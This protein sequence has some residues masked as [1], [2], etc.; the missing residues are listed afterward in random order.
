MASVARA[1]YTPFP[2]SAIVG[3]DEP[4]LAL[5][6]AAINPRVGG[7]LL[8]GPKGTGKTTLVRAAGELLPALE[9]AT[10]PYGCDPNGSNLCAACAATLESG[11]PLATKKTRGEIVELPVNAQLDD[12][13]GAIDLKAA[14]ER[15]T[16]DFRPGLLARANRN[17]L[18]VDEVNLLSDLVVDALLDAAAQGVVHVKRGQHA[19]DYPSR[20]TLIGTMN[21][22]EGELRPQITDRIGLRVFVRS[23]PSFE[24]RLEIY[25]RNASFARDAR[26][27]TATFEGAT[28]KLRTKLAQA[29]KRIESVRV[30]AAAE[31]AAI[32]ATAR[33]G[34]DSHRT[35]FVAL[36]AATALAAWEGRDVATPADV[37]RVFPL[38]ARLR[39]SRL[40]VEAQSEHLAEDAAIEAA[41]EATL[42][43]GANDMPEEQVEPAP[44]IV[45]APELT[46]KT[47]LPERPQREREGQPIGSQ[48][49]GPN[50]RL[51]IGA[52][53]L[54][55]AASSRAGISPEPK[56]PVEAAT[57]PRLSIL[58]VDASLSTQK[59]SELVRA[60]TRELL[61]PVYTDRERAALISCWGPHATIAVD[62]NTGRNID[63]VAARLDELEPGAVRALT[64]LP[65]ALELA[66]TIAERFRRAHA[67]AEVDIAVFSDGR[68]NV[69]LGGE[70]MLAAALDG[71]G[72][73]ELGELAAE[74]C[75]HIAS[76]LAGRAKLTCVNL[77]E[78]E[79][80]PLMREIATLARGT[81]FPLSSVV[82]KIL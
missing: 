5:I 45:V 2:F 59:S 62:E 66:R 34:I 69:P 14:L 21:P 18:Y 78:Y 11:K 42:G 50:G 74:Q 17:V 48:A 31:A 82:A 10:C 64:P 30:D 79:A 28:K 7:V 15:G 36:E 76:Q 47:P 61:R 72:V 53:L 60:A 19:I 71:D 75:R 9:R 6:L 1:T 44:R 4:K 41:L 16:I 67:G 56:E 55:R 58:V 3:Q 26:A 24:E 40:R 46:Q 38:A 63:L 70:A 77:D 49:L 43:E 37:A 13:V 68:A 12:V 22:E 73:R 51:D 81:Y 65:E 32:E 25:R 57:P 8:S 29:L 80:H 20:F 54:D 35:E 23:A 33:L 27:F 52:T 39:R